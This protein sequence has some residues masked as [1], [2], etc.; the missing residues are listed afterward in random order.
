[1]WIK[2]YFFSSRWLD[3]KPSCVKLGFWWI[4]PLKSYRFVGKGKTLIIDCPFPLS[5]VQRFIC[6]KHLLLSICTFAI[7]KFSEQI[8]KYLK[9]P[10][11]STSQL[12]NTEIIW[13]LVTVPTQSWPLPHLPTFYMPT[14]F[15]QTSIPSL[16]IVPLTTKATIKNSKQ[17][18]YYPASQLPF[19]CTWSKL[20]SSISPL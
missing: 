15:L 12:Y 8:S 18:Q 16:R 19:L 3:G 13:E 1:M 6:K 4:F 5:A 2:V 9:L 11:T 20:Q 14:A 17:Q 7:Y 10:F